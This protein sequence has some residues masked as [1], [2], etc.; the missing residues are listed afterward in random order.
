MDA[1]V[2]IA[3][4]F[5]GLALGIAIGTLVLVFKSGGGSVA[6]GSEELHTKYSMKLTGWIQS[7][8]LPYI[9]LT[10]D[11]VVTHTASTATGGIRNP[12]PPP[13]GGD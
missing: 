13:G 9:I 8:L 5:A 4:I 7:E 10:R 12:P 6:A 11:E 2:A 3:L 1:A